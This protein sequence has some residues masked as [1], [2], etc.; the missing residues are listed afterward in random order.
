M[1]SGKPRGINAGRKLKTH[2]RINVYVPLPFVHIWPYFLGGLIRTIT[3]LTHNQSGENH[4]PEPLTLQVSSLKRSPS[5]LNS[6]TLPCVSVLESNSRKTTRESL[7][8]Y[9]GMVVCLS[10]TRTMK[11][12]LLVSVDLVTPS[13]ICQESDSE[14]SRSLEFHSTLS[15]SERRK[16]QLNE[17]SLLFNFF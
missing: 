4:S 5:K 12:L 1:G 6:P 8:S 17:E 10:L 15:G 13:E 14:S 16:S 3:S 9:Q 2:R 11:C 7:P